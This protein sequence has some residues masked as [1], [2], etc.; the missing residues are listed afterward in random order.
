MGG[1]KFESA[2]SP[3]FPNNFFIFCCFFG[4]YSQM[5]NFC[6]YTYLYVEHLFFHTERLG[7]Q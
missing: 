7:E 2:Q 3:N 5:W 4:D 6:W 1:K